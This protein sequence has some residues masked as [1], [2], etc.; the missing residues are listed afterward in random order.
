MA[1]ID[2]VKLILAD[3][4]QIGDGINKFNESTRL[5]EDVPEID[6]MT[7]VSIITSLEE[8]FGFTVDDEIDLEAFETLGSL[9]DYVDGRCSRN[10]Q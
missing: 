6:S 2:E 7:I 8:R 1:T 5:L 3:V 10:C 9:V 4:L